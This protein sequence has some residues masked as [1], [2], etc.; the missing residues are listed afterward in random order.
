MIYIL[1]ITIPIGIARALMSFNLPDYK[2]FNCQSCLSFWIAFA[3]C[4]AVDYN[5]IG[6]SF[7]TYLVSDLI[8]IYESK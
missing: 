4:C 8:L 1:L 3:G 5:L 2:P 7:I 6:M